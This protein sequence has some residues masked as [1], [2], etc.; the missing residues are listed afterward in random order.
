MPTVNVYLSEA[1]LAGLMAYASERQIRVTLLI[2]QAVKEWL[3]KQ[4]GVK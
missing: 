1:E 3:E 2:R 4:K